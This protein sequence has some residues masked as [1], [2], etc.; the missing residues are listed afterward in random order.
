MEMAL[1]SLQQACSKTPCRKLT[2]YGQGVPGTRR[3]LASPPPKSVPGMPTSTEALN[4]AP[5]YFFGLFSV[6]TFFR[7]AQIIMTTPAS[8]MGTDSHC[9]MLME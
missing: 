2:A 6:S 9:P 7:Q 3:A 5:D 1:L 4:G 8:I